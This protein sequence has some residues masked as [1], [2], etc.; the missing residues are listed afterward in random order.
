MYSGPSG[1]RAKRRLCQMELK[2]C[3]SLIYN[4]PFCPNSSPNLCLP[5]DFVLYVPCRKAEM[6]FLTGRWWR[7]IVSAYQ[8]SDISTSVKSRFSILAFGY[9]FPRSGCGS[10]GPWGCYS[11]VLPCLTWSGLGWRVW[12][13][14]Y[15]NI[16]VFRSRSD[17]KQG[18]SH[19]CSSFIFLLD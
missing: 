4:I 17:W 6:D 19:D 7:L 3:L 16:C 10:V 1:E 12:I 14:K 2:C 13:W 8:L 5:S 9:C 11:R 15:I 18:V